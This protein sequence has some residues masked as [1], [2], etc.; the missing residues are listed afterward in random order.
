MVCFS[1]LL[2][3]SAFITSLPTIGIII[4]PSICFFISYS[5]SSQ[6]VYFS[7]SITSH[8]FLPTAHQ[9]TNNYP[10]KKSVAAKKAEPE[11][12]R[13]KRR[14]QRSSKNNKILNLVR[15][16][17]SGQRVYQRHPHYFHPFLSMMAVNLL[18]PL[19]KD[20]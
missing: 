11:G 16:L 3:S 13:R 19:M 10:S 6:P 1:L 20:Q 5:K 7:R 2:P 14:E 17:V 12:G 8:P 18:D 9:I 4:I 15:I